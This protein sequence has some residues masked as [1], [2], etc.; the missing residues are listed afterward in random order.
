M[1]KLL[2]ALLVILLISVILFIIT[3]C[4]AVYITVMKLM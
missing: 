3:G 4:F 2:T 1:N